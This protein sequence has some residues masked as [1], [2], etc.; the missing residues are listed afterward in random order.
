MPSPPDP[1]AISIF[2][3][4]VRWYAIFILAGV[5]SGFALSRFI[6]ARVGLDPEWVLDIAP[7][8]VFA[9]I[10]GGRIYY[11]L[12][13]G[14]ELLGRPLDAINIRG[15]G[16]SFHGGLV[17]G[18]LTLWWLCRRDGQ[19]FFSWAD[20][21]VPGAALAQA[22]GRW[23][24]WTNQEAFG[25]PTA[26]PWGL[27]IDPGHRPP[28]FEAFERFHP[29]F[30]YESIFN[31]VNALLLTWLALRVP[32]SQR[33]RHGDVL[34]LYLI[35]YGVARFLIERVRTD[36]LYIGPL[37]AAFWLSGSLVVAGIAI[38]AWNHRKPGDPVCYSP[39]EET[40]GD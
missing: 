12:L 21:A 10:A 31:L 16:L 25:T 30:L 36:S 29:T 9:S 3:V 4:D 26:L 1:V 7:W 15:G 17:A 19:S 33:L 2:G 37:P 39:A 6:A 32:H 11:V 40:A 27:W 14:S 13:R 5:V 34:A 8:I 23:G 18:T 35:G 20:V 38:L 22:I 24:N 28:G